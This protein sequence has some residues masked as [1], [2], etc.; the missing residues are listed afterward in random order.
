MRKIAALWLLCALSLLLPGCGMRSGES[1]SGPT[2]APET[3]TAIPAAAETP[4]PAPTETPEPTPE[5]TAVPPAEPQWVKGE[6]SRS[7]LLLC[8]PGAGASAL[9][10]WLMG[11]GGALLAAYVPEKL[12]EPMFTLA[13]TPRDNAADIPAAGEENRCV[14]LAADASLLES[15]A[16]GEILPVF[17]KEYGYLVEVCSGTADNVQDWAGSGRTDV[18]LMAEDAAAGLSRRGFD[19]VTAYAGTFYLLE[20]P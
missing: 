7:Y 6:K 13:F 14:R 1:E 18:T 2:P 19:S 5:P 15:G 12:T 11:E 16:L 3:A 9:K 17:E 20:T 8:A 4:M 10:N